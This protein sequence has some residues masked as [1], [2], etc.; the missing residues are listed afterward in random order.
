MKN[1]KNLKIVTIIYFLIIVFPCKIAFINFIILP[2]PILNFVL[3]LGVDPVDLM[4]FSEPIIS[5]ITILSIFYIFN[6]KK[7]IVISSIIIQYLYLTYLFKDKFLNYW[8]F[9]IPTTI[10]LILSLLL[11][12]NLFSHKKKAINN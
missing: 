5:I 11:I 12:Y 6:K 8:Y 4:S 7:H 3:M 1:I 10:Y 9:T 2:L